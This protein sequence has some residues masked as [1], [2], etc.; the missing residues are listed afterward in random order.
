MIKG[1]QIDSE[2]AVILTDLSQEN[3]RKVEKYI[4]DLQEEIF[5]LNSEIEDLEEE[6]RECQFC[7]ENYKGLNHPLAEVVQEIINN[8]YYNYNSYDTKEKII[9]RLEHAL[10]YEVE[11]WI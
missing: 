8:Q 3:E 9:E 1:K 4:E 5:D 2:I 10:K 7:C 11:R 6:Q